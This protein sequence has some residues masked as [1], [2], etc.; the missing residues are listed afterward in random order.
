MENHV[1]ALSTGIVIQ[2]QRTMEGRNKEE[3]LD[4]TFIPMNG[5]QIRAGIWKIRS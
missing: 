1:L 4:E 3:G 2:G 5:K